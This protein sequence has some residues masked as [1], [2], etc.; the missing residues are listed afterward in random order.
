[1]DD[2]A[3]DLSTVIRKYRNLIHPGRT[4]RLAKTVDRSGAIVA[5]QVVEIISKQVA[6]RKQET[7]GYTAEQLFNRLSGGSSALSLVAHLMKDTPRPEIGR[8]LTSVLPNAYFAASEDINEEPGYSDHLLTCY[9]SVF[10]LAPDETKTLVSK[11][12][13]DIYRRE[14]EPTVNIYE[15]SSLEDPISRSNAR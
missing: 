7:Y 8:L 10:D 3:V 13:Y 4:K 6:K 12:L 14:P 15:D 1:M 11:H 2:E 5:A 9:R